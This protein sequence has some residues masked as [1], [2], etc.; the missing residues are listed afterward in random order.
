MPTQVVVQKPGDAEGILYDGAKVG[1]ESNDYRI[2][3][4]P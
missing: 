4:R 2:C 1:P 3:P